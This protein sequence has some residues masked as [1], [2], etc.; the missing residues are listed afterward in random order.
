MVILF[1][2]GKTNAI[3]FNPKL[4]QRKAAQSDCIAALAQLI[5]TEGRGALAQLVERVVRN[6]EV[7]GSIPLSST[8]PC[9]IA[10]GRY[11]HDNRAILS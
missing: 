1:D 2:F 5:L 8:T 7:S 9:L 4:D 6:D 10:Y 11:A 3:R